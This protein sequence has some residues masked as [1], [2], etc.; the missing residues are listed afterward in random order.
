LAAVAAGEPVD[1][2]ERGA[3]RSE[4]SVR[5]QQTDLSEKTDLWGV[6]I[7][8]MS[9]FAVAVYCN[10]HR[11]GNKGKAKAWPSTGRAALCAQL[12]GELR[13]RVRMTVAPPGGGSGR[14][15]IVSVEQL[16]TAPDRDRP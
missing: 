12:S 1:L 7:G 10:R 15:R 3:E 2:D 6:R 9:V 11:G 8:F 5:C 14:A 4:T 16:R 13:A